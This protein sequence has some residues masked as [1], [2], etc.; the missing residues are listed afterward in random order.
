MH[1]SE[2]ARGTVKL[3]AVILAQLGQLLLWK[4]VVSHISLATAQEHSLLCLHIVPGNEPAWHA[5]PQD[6]VWERHV[7]RAGDPPL[8]RKAYYKMC[9]CTVKRNRPQRKLT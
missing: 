6:D 8:Q 7:G 3:A 9:L 5:A 2:V 1:S 4:P